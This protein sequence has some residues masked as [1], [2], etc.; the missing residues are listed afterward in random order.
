M[1]KNCILLL[2]NSTFNDRIAFNVINIWNLQS[3]NFRQQTRIR[4]E[5]ASR[6]EQ[7]TSVMREN[8]A[9]YF[10]QMNSILT[11]P[12]KFVLMSINEH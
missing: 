12:N 1:F 10:V 4:G 5:N 6:R 2:G 3:K 11:N 9:W 8:T 7:Y